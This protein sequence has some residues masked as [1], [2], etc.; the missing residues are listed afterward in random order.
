MITEQTFAHLRGFGAKRE[1]WIKAAHPLYRADIEKDWGFDDAAYIR[2]YLLGSCILGACHAPQMSPER[3]L[4]QI[5]RQAIDHISFRV[6]LA[7]ASDL[8]VDGG[9][10]DIRAGHLQV[11]DMAQPMRSHSRGSKPG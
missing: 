10:V 6:F 4:E 5:S 2:N 9:S 3:T 8:H 7:G 1:T 11:L